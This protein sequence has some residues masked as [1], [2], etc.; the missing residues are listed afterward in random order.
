MYSSLLRVAALAVGFSLTCSSCGLFVGESPPKDPAPSFSG[1]GY[2]C[3]G[4]IPAH[5]EKYVLDKLSPDEITEFIRCLQRSFA[6][7]AQYTRG[8]DAA[9]YTPD[10]IRNFL[11]SYFLKDRQISDAL[12]REFMVIKQTVVGGENDRITRAELRQ[13]IDF[14]ED[15]RKEAIRLKPHL[16]VLN[17]NLLRN[18]DPAQL[19]SRLGEAIE[20]LNESIGSF[21]RRLT[22]GKKPYSFDN[23]EVFL[24]EFRSFVDWESHF[25]DAIDVHTWVDFVRIFKELSVSPASPRGVEVA[26]WSTLLKNLSRWYSVYLQYT[27]GVKESSLW[28]GVGLQNLFYLSQEVF[29]LVGEAVR[30]QSSLT[31]TFEQIH[32]LTQVMRRLGWIPEHIRAES[33]DQA[34]RALVQT[35]F[36]D[37]KIP[38][39]SRNAQ[40]LTPQALSL[41][42]NAFNRWVFIQLNL[43]ARFHPAD[44]TAA[45]DTV[46]NLRRRWFLPEDVRRQ[47]KDMQGS[48]WTEFMRV[49][50]MHDKQKDFLRPLFPDKGDDREKRRVFLV[51]EDDLVKHDLIYGFHNLSMMNLVRSL[52]QLIVQGYGSGSGRAQGWT[53]GLKSSELQRFY[54]DFYNLGVDLRIID[55]RNCT[56][57]TRAFIEG[58]LF[59]YSSDGLGRSGEESDAM[60]KLTEAIELFSF[61]YSGGELGDEMYGLLLARCAK[62]P[63]DIYG[64][65]TVQRACVL[66]SL[67]GVLIESA[68]HMPGLRR[69]L[70]AS[71][72]ER[73]LEY[74]ETLLATAISPQHSDAEWVELNE[75]STVAVVAQYA[76]AVMTRYDVNRDHQLDFD[77]VDTAEPVFSAFIG[78]FIEDKINRF[79]EEN[80]LGG[81][82]GKYVAQWCIPCTRGAFFYILMHKKIPEPEDLLGRITPG[83]MNFFGLPD[84]GVLNLGLSSLITRAE[85]NWGIRWWQ[86]TM[87]G[88]TGFD[89]MEIATVFKVI[90]SEI[91][92]SAPSEPKKE[93]CAPTNRGE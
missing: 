89:R 2:S 86:P 54:Q 65:R 48:D 56:A 84:S 19:G 39:S 70:Q 66:R 1:R 73:Q 29:D 59:T 40:G 47:L 43:D 33:V 92:K 77:E 22:H 14:L 24:K 35:V 93:S 36:E 83:W 50:Q 68:F 9:T 63:L 79:L 4:Q 53:A 34:V 74:A 37:P 45:A 10:E 57:G 13:A 25:P 49:M 75:L 71:A 76:E 85:K 69:F 78:K 23:L 90:I 46:P 72:P 20:A 81:A 26:Q 44:R 31:L 7:F 12:L 11:H 82:Y 3:V 30:S 64:R 41:M 18:E 80:E 38:P 15:V 58:N 67:P 52:V 16:R 17:P 32:E 88:K 60:L 6:S 5:I 61:L 62:G 21:S 27:A 28:R 87:N 8:D 91:F 51:P 42:E 55:R